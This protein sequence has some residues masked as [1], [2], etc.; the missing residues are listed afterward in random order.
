MSTV[1]VSGLNKLSASLFLSLESTFTSGSESF[2]LDSL[3]ESSLTSWPFRSKQTRQVISLTRFSVFLVT[4]SFKE[5][6]RERLVVTTTVLMVQKEYD[7]KMFAKAFWLFS[8]VLRTFAPKSSYGEIFFI[9]RL[10]L[11]DKVLTPKMKKK[12][13]TDFVSEKMAVE[14]Y[15][16]FDKSV[17]ITRC[18]LLC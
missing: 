7:D 10:E 3:P 2:L 8:L 16:N 1:R 12:W 13:V 5:K 15:L 14:K 18:S 17:I 11:V 9:S 6:R 4:I